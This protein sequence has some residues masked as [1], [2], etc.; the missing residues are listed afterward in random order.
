MPDRAAP[1][2]ILTL[3]LPCDPNAPR[4]VRDALH[5]LDWL[6]W[7]LGDVTLVA[8]ELVANAVTHS[9]AQPDDLLQVR[10]ELAGDRLRIAVHDPGRS[11]SIAHVRTGDPE[12]GG[13]WGLLIVEQLSERWGAESSD[14]QLV[15]ADVALPVTATGSATGGEP[16]LSPGALAA[17][18]SV[19]PGG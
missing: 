15:W 14:G 18:E 5:E 17:R 10:A 2:P 8:S 13:G 3:E 9:G 11:G 12:A 16:A 4:L 7:V 1:K 6:G 19:P